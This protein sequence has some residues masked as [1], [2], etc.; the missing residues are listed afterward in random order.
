MLLFDTKIVCSCTEVSL[1]TCESQVAEV[2]LIKNSAP[3]CLSASLSILQPKSK[4]LRDAEKFRTRSQIALH[5]NERIN[6]PTNRQTFGTQDQAA[7]ST[8][9]CPADWKVSRSSMT[10]G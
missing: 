8:L 2:G 9:H 6:Q 5:R 7:I 1:V 4:I 3:I 10:G